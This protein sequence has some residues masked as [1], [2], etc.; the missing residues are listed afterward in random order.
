MLLCDTRDSHLWKAG[1]Q[2]RILV[3]NGKKS[4][5]AMFAMADF[6]NSRVQLNIVEFF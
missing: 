2:Y 6:D 3:R 5:V 4:I 1:E